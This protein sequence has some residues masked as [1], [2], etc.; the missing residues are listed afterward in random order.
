MLG[1]SEK[2]YRRQMRRALYERKCITTHV[3]CI[4]THVILC[5]TTHVICIDM[6]HLYIALNGVQEGT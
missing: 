4:T 2:L 3:I 6:M 1:G 5:I